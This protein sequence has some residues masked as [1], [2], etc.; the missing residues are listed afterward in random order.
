VA[1]R[2][3]AALDAVIDEST[4]GDKTI[5]AAQ[6]GKRIV[7]SSYLIVAAGA[8]TARWKSGSTNKSGPLTIAANGGVSAP[9][10]S[11][12]RWFATGIGEALVL[13]LGG[14]IVVGGHVSYYLEP[15]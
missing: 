11:D 4:A 13:N 9:G 8:V 10:G 14:A 15:S 2:S 1:E 7:V 12:S 6:S 3:S 5:V